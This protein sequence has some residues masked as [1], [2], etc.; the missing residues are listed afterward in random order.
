M[1]AGRRCAL[2]TRRAH[3]HIICKGPTAAAQCGGAAGGGPRPGGP[4]I[5]GRGGGRGED[6]RAPGINC[7]LSH[8]RDVRYSY[9]CALR[10]ATIVALYNFVGTTTR[11][12][13]VGHEL[14]DLLFYINSTS[15]RQTLAS[16]CIFSWI[17][18]IS[19]PHLESP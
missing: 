12:V 8:S 2:R 15:T 11:L 1:C 17:S 6:R 19:I 7:V 13:Q 5:Q 18:R 3:A 9:M 16:A 14:V 4:P 10:P